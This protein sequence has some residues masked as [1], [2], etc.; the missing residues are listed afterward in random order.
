MSITRH[1]VV[2]WFTT[3]DELRELADAM[4][5]HWKTCAP[6]QDKTVRSIFGKHTEL[7]IL[8]DQEKIKSPGWWD[9]RKKR[10]EVPR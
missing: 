5:K 4:E 3:P 10:I 7:L 9:E 1:E 2:H 6:G 8:V